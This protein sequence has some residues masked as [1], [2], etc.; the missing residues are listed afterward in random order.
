MVWKKIAW[1]SSL[2][3]LVL[4]TLLLGAMLAFTSWLAAAYTRAHPLDLAPYLPRIESML[5]AQGLNITFGTLELY[6]D[7]SPV[8]RAESI[9]VKGPDGSLGVFIEKA[10]IKL[11]NRNLW[12]VQ[13]AP[14]LIAAKRGRVWGGYGKHH[15]PRRQPQKCACHQPQPG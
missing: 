9:Q 1:W 13:A 6:Y 14:K 4:G 10:A 5:A 15:R 7:D 12:R 3:T 11:A 8:L 2:S